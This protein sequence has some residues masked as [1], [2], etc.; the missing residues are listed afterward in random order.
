MEHGTD[1]AAI[2][3]QGVTTVVLIEGFIVSGETK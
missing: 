2:S 1:V 3:V